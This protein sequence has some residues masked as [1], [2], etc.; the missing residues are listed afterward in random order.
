MFVDCLIGKNIKFSE[1]VV[2]I[3]RSYMNHE[4]WLTGEYFSNFWIQLA[5][6]IIEE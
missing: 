5:M 3:A 2:A 1:S 6:A 4:Y